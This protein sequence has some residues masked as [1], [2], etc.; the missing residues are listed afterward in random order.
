MLT[1]GGYKGYVALEYEDKQDASAAVPRLIGKLQK[2]L[3]EV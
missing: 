2:M 3:K 1:A